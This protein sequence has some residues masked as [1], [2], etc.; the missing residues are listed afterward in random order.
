MDTKYGLKNWQHSTSTPVQSGPCGIFND[1]RCAL[2]S[3]ISLDISKKHL[4]TNLRLHNSTYS[5]HGRVGSA[6]N[7]S[8]PQNTISPNAFA[9]PCLPKRTISQVSHSLY[10]S[11]V[12]H[13]QKSCYLYNEIRGQIF[14]WCPNHTSKPFISDNHP[15]LMPR[16]QVR[17]PFRTSKVYNLQFILELLTA[18]DKG[19][20][21]SQAVG[22]ISVSLATEDVITLN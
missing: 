18:H 2:C 15:S 10:L 6:C 7:V 1:T 21:V 14:P 16:L 13:T 12:Y 19:N 20:S 8:L 4:Q 22:M 9:S 5:R 17:I 3:Y 11:Q